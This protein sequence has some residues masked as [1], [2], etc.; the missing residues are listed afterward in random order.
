[1]TRDDGI[2]IEPC[3]REDFDAIVTRHDEYWDS[4][5]TLRLHHPIFIHEFGDTAYVIRDGDRIAAYLFGFFAQTGPVAYV[6]LVAVHPDHRGRGLARRLYEHFIGVARRRGCTELKATADPGNGLS[7]GF[8]KSI[9]MELT[10]E[11][12]S[13]GVPVVEGYLRPG[14]DRVVFRMPIP[15]DPE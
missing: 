2:S 11:P 5:L 7:I 3:T 4:D 9:G 15:P 6:H 10:G 8:H 1:M 12:N 14:V 13:D